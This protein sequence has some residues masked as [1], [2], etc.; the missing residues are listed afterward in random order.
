MFK[1]N[2]LAWDDNLPESPYLRP[3]TS[4]S[5][6]NFETTSLNSD[7]IPHFKLKSHYRSQSSLSDTTNLEIESEI[8]TLP[9][10]NPYIEIIDEPYNTHII[11]TISNNNDDVDDVVEPDNAHIIETILNEG[12]DEE[13]DDESEGID[14]INL[15]DA[16]KYDKVLNSQYDQDMK[17]GKIKPKVKP[18]VKDV[19]KKTKLFKNKSNKSNKSIND[20]P[21][22]SITIDDLLE[23]DDISEHVVT[24]DESYSEEV[25]KW[26]NEMQS[27]INTLIKTMY[28]YE[29]YTIDG[30]I[31]QHF[32]GDMPI[33][34]FYQSNINDTFKSIEELERIQPKDIYNGEIYL[35]YNSD[36]TVHTFKT[37]TTN[38]MYNTLSTKLHNKFENATIHHQ[39]VKTDNVVHRYVLRRE[40]PLDSDSRY[41]KERKSTQYIE[42]ER[43]ILTPLYKKNKIKTFTPVNPDK[44]FK[45]N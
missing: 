9:P 30:I 37:I 20:T 11:E 5:S 18:S 8:K 7:V 25:L 27:R 10:I 3:E 24:V 1:S 21:T 4:Y 22:S 26:R 2:I 28:Q 14:I 23:L 19:K 39:T 41:R 36:N 38:K 31:R 35:T 13:P 6:A 15:G 34:A 40:Y 17:S 16:I 33:R 12:E 44:M 43:I 29:L 42:K 32:Y 45:M